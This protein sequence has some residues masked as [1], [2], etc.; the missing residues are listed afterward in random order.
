MKRILSFGAVF[1][2]LFACA[3]EP[4]ACECGKNLMK[5]SQEQD[6]DLSEACEKHV[7]SL[8]DSAQM[9]WYNASME[10]MNEQ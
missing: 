7:A 8:P 10:C 9:N 6:A 1:L 4:N 2:V 5:S 3:K